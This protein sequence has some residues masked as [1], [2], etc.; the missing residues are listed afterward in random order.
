M[1][2]S[3]LGLFIIVLAG[4]SQANAPDLILHN[5]RIITLDDGGPTDATAVAVRGGRVV[6]VGS[7]QR[8][9]ALRGPLTRVVDLGGAVVVPGLVDSHCHLQGLGKSLAQID[10]MDTP[11]AVACIQQVADAMAEMPGTSWLQ[12]RGWDQNDWEIR[13]YPHRSLLDEVTGDRPCLLRRVDGHAAWVN[14]AALAAA[15]IDRDTPD[16]AGGQILRDA[17]GE[18]T[19]ILIDNGVDLVSGNIPRPDRNEVRRRILLAVEHCLAHGLTAVHDAG[20]TWEHADIYE[21]MARTG[22]L[23]LRYYGMLTDDPET[24]E[25]GFAHG[26]RSAKDGL[27]TVRAVK[28]YADGALGSRGAML[29]ED[30]TDQP[31][32]RGLPVTPQY[33]MGDVCR[34]AARA[35]FQVG[36]HAI[37]DA[38]NRMVLDMY[39]EVVTELGLQDHRWRV[40]HAQILAPE[41]IPRF[42]Q[43]GV[44]AAMQPVHCTSDMD[45]ADE[46]LGEERLLGAYAWRSLLDSGAHV[47]SGTDFPVE[48][49]SALAGLFAA[50]TRTHPD[51]TPLGGWQPQEM[52]DGRT[53]LELATTESAYAAFAEHELGRVR[54]G[55]R[56]DLTVLDGDP[57]NCE[58]AEL[59]TMKV[60]MTV[61]DG[62]VLYQAP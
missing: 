37:G 8:A 28:L 42:G 40:E 9:L 60:V 5:A 6:V 48:R 55:F 27:F 39:Q 57:V 61:V 20:V 25:P 10:L 1:R 62:R 31:G 7:D 22:E 43:L 56:A 38:A 15:G 23:S 53:A 59:L 12:G 17:D 51:G 52:L 45:W 33:H 4:C 35:G 18:P 24:L 41:D 47:C 21:Q 44:I 13:E 30:Y 16:P 29:L 19:G 36:T 49:V 46:R 34:R 58:P 14:T 26:P 3:L 50:R 2:R 32:H 54:E 11:S